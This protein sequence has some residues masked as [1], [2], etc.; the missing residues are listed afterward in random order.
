MNI[1]IVKIAAFLCLLI[2]QVSAQQNYDL[3]S[4]RHPTING[5]QGGSVTGT[6]DV[7]QNLSVT[8]NFGEVSAANPNKVVKVVVPI[9]VRSLQPYQVIVTM[10][11]AGN[12][13]PRA[14]QLSDIG[15]GANNM[16]VLGAKGQICT[17]STH[18]FNSSFNTDPSTSFSIDANGR[19]AYQASL[20]NLTLSTVILTGPKLTQGTG[21]S[22]R[23]DDGWVFDAIF[24][25]TPQF[26]NSGTSSVILT[27]TISP[28]PNV[29]C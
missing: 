16:R 7:T 8:V 15:F 9:A 3:S 17:K 1:R 18:I 5:A 19:V 22:R 21:S 20:A 27:F 6:A 14:I 23:T 10:T 4:G 28:G 2:I 13:D 24:V 25:I 29:Q 12:I 26:F 11:G